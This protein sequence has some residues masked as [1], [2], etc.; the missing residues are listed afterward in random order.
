MDCFPLACIDDWSWVIEYDLVV[1]VWH[2]RSCI[3]TLILLVH[4]R[5]LRC[6]CQVV[7]WWHIKFSKACLICR[8]HRNRL[9]VKVTILHHAAGSF[10]LNIRDKVAATHANLSI[11]LG[12]HLMISL[13]LMVAEGR[14]WSHRLT[15]WRRVVMLALI[16]QLQLLTLIV[17]DD[18]WVVLCN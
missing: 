1:L 17:V 3:H 16:I 7:I 2:R 12:L 4:G 9:V 6:L 18:R 13:L 15:N 5:L 8:D 14:W 11:L 10:N